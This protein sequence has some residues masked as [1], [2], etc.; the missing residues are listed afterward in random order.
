M[1]LSVCAWWL[2][3]FYLLFL[4]FLWFPTWLSPEVWKKKECL[5]IVS[6]FRLRERQGGVGRSLSL[7]PPSSVLRGSCSASGKWL[8]HI[9]ACAHCLVYSTHLTWEST[10]ELLIRTLFVSLSGS[11]VQVLLILI[12]WW[13]GFFPPLGI[14][15]GCYL[16]RLACLGVSSSLLEEARLI[17]KSPGLKKSLLL[18]ISSD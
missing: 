15:M 10:E 8:S 3:V 2:F 6:F 13:I 5:G 11:G 18:P 17:H 1:P 16:F 12:E 4:R 14:L 9:L 7:R